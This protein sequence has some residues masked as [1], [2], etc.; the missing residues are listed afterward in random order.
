[1][2]IVLIMTIFLTIAFTTFGGESKEA[3]YLRQGAEYLVVKNYQRAVKVFGTAAQLNPASVEAHRGLGMAYLK[4]G[5]NEVASDPEMLEN[6]ASAFR[7][8]V[9]LAPGSAEN[10][11]HL[12]LT[13]LALHDKNGAMREYESIKGLDAA[14]AA[15]LRA[16]ISS[17]IPPI[18]YRPETV[19][20][21]AGDY[22]TRVTISRNQ[23]FVPV[24]LIL[25]N[26]T[27]EVRLLLDTG[28]SVTVIST[29][30][31]EK[32]DI[33]LNRASRSR[34]QVV[35]GGMVTGWHTKLDRI[36]AGPHTMTGIDVAII[37]NEGRGFAI[38]GL[39]GMNFLRSYKYHIDFKNQAIDWAP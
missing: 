8:S 22:L 37:P 39:L 26:R 29:D 32:L 23:V 20:G 28:A 36:S 6:A 18:S 25:G 3:A 10:R 11:Y 31:A 4:L 30:V 1:M 13:Y 33:D 2:K 24:T 7:E 12:A 14:V 15:Q 38:D 17:Y 16:R 19:T 35:G 34:A 5:S 27:V 21:L 9:S